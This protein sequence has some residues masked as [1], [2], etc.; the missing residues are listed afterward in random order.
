[1]P[2]ATGRTRPW[3]CTPIHRNTRSVDA[4][5]GSGRSVQQTKAGIGLVLDA[6]MRVL[7]VNA[8]GAA[9]KSGRVG[10][11]DR[12]VA[13]DGVG[14]EGLPLPAVTPLI[15]GAPGTPVSVSVL[16]TVPLTRQASSPS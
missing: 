3:F 9:R 15:A 4:E 2:A 11:G 8:D 5:A 1:M 6:Q 10:I 12:I 13:V 7:S 16:R 14:V